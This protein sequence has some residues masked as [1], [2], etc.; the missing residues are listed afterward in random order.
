MATTPPPPRSTS[1]TP[2]EG[3]APC[4]ADARQNLKE[5]EEIVH[6]LARDIT[7]LEKL[8]S[9]DSL[10]KKIFSQIRPACAD[11][12]DA[13]ETTMAD[14]AAA[15]A[16]KREELDEREAEHEEIDSMLDMVARAASKDFTQ[17]VD[18]ALL[19]QSIV[20][21]ETVKE[22]VEERKPPGLDPKVM[23]EIEEGASSEWKRSADAACA[24]RP[25]LSEGYV[26]IFNEATAMDEAFDEDSDH[27]IH[28][29]ARDA[30]EV[31]GNY[32][33]AE[34][35][36]KLLEDERKEFD[37][38]TYYDEHGSPTTTKC[39][40]HRS[41]FADKSVPPLRLLGALWDKLAQHQ[42]TVIEKT[43]VNL[44][45]GYGILNGQRMGNGK[46]LSTMATLEGLAV[47]G[48]PFHAVLL[49]PKSMTTAWMNEFEMWE[50]LLHYAFFQF[51]ANDDKSL[52]VWKA[53]G[54]L[55][56][57]T[58]DAFK[59]K[60]VDLELQKDHIIIVDEAGF[61]KKRKTELHES[62]A[63]S[64]ARRRILL[65]GT[66]VQNNL[67]EMYWLLQLVKPGCF[68]EPET[69]VKQYDEPIRAGQ[70]RDASDSAKALCKARTFSFQKIASVYWDDC[71]ALERLL[72]PKREY[73]VVQAVD[74]AFLRDMASTTPKDDVTQPQRLMDDAYDHKEKKV[75]YAVD[76][77]VATPKDECVVVFGNNLAALDQLK[78]ELDAIGG[79]EA[80]PVYNGASSVKERADLIA[81]FQTG[82]YKAI[83][84][85]TL[86]GGVGISLVRGNHVIVLNPEWNPTNTTQ[87]VARV[88]RFGQQRPVTVVHLITEKTIE[89]KMYVKALGKRKL[90][91]DILIDENDKKEVLTLAEMTTLSN[92]LAHC[93]TVLERCDWPA[94]VLKTHYGA[95]PHA[96]VMV[97]DHDAFLVD[98]EESM[99]PKDERMA[100]HDYNKM[101]R[102]HDRVLVPP[103]ATEADAQTIKPEQILFDKPYEMCYTASYVPYVDYARS[104]AT[105]VTVVAGPHLTYQLQICQDGDGVWRDCHI[106]LPTDSSVQCV[107]DLTKTKQPL[108]DCVFRCRP[109]MIK[110]GCMDSAKNK[111]MPWSDASVTFS[112]MDF[113]PAAS[114][115]A[116]SAS[117]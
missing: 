107:V 64:A 10:Y 7:T 9:E 90:Q 79:L 18:L 76:Y 106:A 43:W 42:K 45:D 1:P 24:K 3:A 41:T 51:Q 38:I 46:S 102:V 52:R 6:E 86:S 82:K 109:V 98:T 104:S 80:L 113:A 87:A 66:P 96:P 70:A 49:H 29:A 78:A 57:L 89:Q 4:L 33:E 53:K 67:T 99:S 44:H 94:A 56:A 103:K 61:Y 55:L 72:K 58:H 74:P 27:E 17:E 81:Q 37:T 30:D 100:H 60:K 15:I 83:L 59:S 68:G 115:S 2:A 91:Q 21:K 26:G 39:V 110:D 23:R 69:F 111:Q 84:V 75:A 35:A 5:L 101:L 32:T 63:S 31:S 11:D 54:G 8:T 93:E 48:E 95:R 22:L 114:A 28:T 116:S 25:R 40:W 117:S 36:T 50:H 92:K 71:S 34:L 12:A 88:W 65:T 77:I 112:P 16:S 20:D 19:D 13:H 105:S 47:L 73:K 85:S 97:T 62:I 14:I 108:S